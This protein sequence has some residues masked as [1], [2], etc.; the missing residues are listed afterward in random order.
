MG[1]TAFSSFFRELVEGA[2][3]ENGR[4]GKITAYATRRG[5]DQYLF[6]HAKNPLRINALKSWVGWSKGESV[7]HCLRMSV[8]TGLSSLSSGRHTR[9]VHPRGHAED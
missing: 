4:I 5:G 6:I 2:G 9:K 8:P 3:L 7:R 1:D